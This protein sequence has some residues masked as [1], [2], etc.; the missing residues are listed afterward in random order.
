MGDAMFDRMLGAARRGQLT[1]RDV[2]ERG[3]KLGMSTAAITALMAAAPEVG[4]SPRPASL[5]T[6]SRA[7]GTATGTFT[8]IAEEASPDIDPHS[9][10]NNA[11]ARILLASHEMLIQFKGESTTEYE[12]MLAESWEASADNSTFT[13]KIPAGATF[14]DGDPCTANEVKA[15]FERFL[16]M[17]MGPVNVISRFAPDPAMIEVV[18]DVTVRFNLGK[19]QPLFLSAMA[20]SYGPFVINPREVEEN[21]TDEDP[22]AHEFFLNG[23]VGTGPYTIVENSLSEQVVFEKYEGY[24]GGWESP[25]FDKIVIRIVDESATR[26]QLLE[27]GDGDA[28][29]QSLTPEDY[30]ALKAN[31]DVIVYNYPSTAVYWTIMN[32]PRLLTPEVR[33][34]FSYAFPYDEIQNGVYKGLITRTGPLARNVLG[35]DPEVFLYQTDLAKA[36]EL[37]L[38]GGFAEGDSFEYVFASGEALERSV[39]ELFQANI[40]EMGFNLDISELDSATYNDLIYGDAPAEEHP[41][42][43]GGWAWWPDYNDA[44]NQLI[45]NFAAASSGGG[46]S[47]AGYYVNDRIEE[48]LVATEN[49]TDQAEYDAL[50]KEA[51]NILTELDPPVLYY[52]ELL[53]TTVTRKDIAGFGSNPLYLSAYPFRKMYRQM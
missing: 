52:G 3:L 27:N 46:G 49:F 45:P 15:S 26:R 10:Y 32:A 38:A 53:W 16:L 39:A 24:H 47:N 25:H 8:I 12:P 23:S 11:A 21:K 51:Q 43:M 20:S 5:R 13:F 7:Q 48:I 41:H 29:D 14:Q 22:W 17:G 28:L 30:E 37:I 50:M 19:P 44:W 35:Y 9:A 34:G 36:K 40:A 42:F 18:D 33:Q 6:L 1:R 4:A 31:P 2:L